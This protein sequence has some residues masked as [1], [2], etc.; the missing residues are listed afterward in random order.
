M[1]EMVWNTEL[2]T[3]AQRWADQ[4]IYDHDPWRWKKDYTRV[5]QN[6]Y[7]NIG[8]KKSLET[9]QKNMDNVTKSWYNQVVNP[10]FD[11]KDISKFR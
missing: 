1:R 4:C 7:I 5:G 11:P 3:I 10:G 9:V 2:E 6:D 8:S